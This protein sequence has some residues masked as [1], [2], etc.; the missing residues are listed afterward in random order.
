MKQCTGGCREMRLN[1]GEIPHTN[2]HL[3]QQGCHNL[4]RGRALCER[5]VDSLKTKSD[6]SVRQ[7]S[8]VTMSGPSVTDWAN[9][10]S[11]KKM[12]L[13]CP[14]YPASI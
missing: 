3:C 4:Y 13:V 9:R 12:V 7:F 8:S 6:M 5:L 2:P 10:I 1:G 14:T 11:P